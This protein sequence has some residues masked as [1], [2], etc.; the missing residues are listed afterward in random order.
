MIKQQAMK[1][2]IILLSVLLSQIALAQN[3]PSYVPTNGL[4]GWWPFSGNAIDSSGNGNNGTVN[5]AILTS[6]R[7]GNANKAYLFNGTDNYISTVNI[8]IQNTASFAFWIEPYLNAAGNNS[9]NYSASLIDQNQDAI[10]NSGF[11]IYYNN[12]SG[13]GLYAQ[14]GYSGNN[15]TSII[16]NINLTLNNWHHIVLT[17]TNGTGKFYKDGALIYTQ[18][19]LTTISPTSNVLLFGKAPWAS[20]AN[21][22]NGKLDD[23]GIWNRALTQQEISALYNYAPASVNNLNCKKFSVYPNPAQDKLYIK[24]LPD[25]MQLKIYNAIGQLML[26]SDQKEINIASL[27]KGNY[28]ISLFDEQKQLIQNQLLI[29]E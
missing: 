17:Y 6:D 27:S 5:G 19:G 20:N 10:G 9:F 12:T 24:D 4:V 3:V 15:N 23:I 26:V 22:Y 2:I 14:I 28:F 1:K 25:G 29:K 18:T 13:N 8:N 21:L 16:T 7:F 11:A